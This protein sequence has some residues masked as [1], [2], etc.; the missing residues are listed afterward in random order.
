M[1]LQEPLREAER[2]NFAYFLSI[3]DTDPSKFKVASVKGSQLIPA[4]FE[5]SGACAGCGET[6]NV[7]LISQM[8][9]DRAM[10]A[11]A[12]GC[13]SIYGGT[14]PSVPYT[15]NKAGRGP[16]WANSLFEDNAEFGLGILKVNSLPAVTETVNPRSYKRM[17]ANSPF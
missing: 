10:I 1:A 17:S 6:A 14:A 4:M 12:T 11:N 8:F 9:G 3:P 7:K 15:T 16:A 13:S 5:F 2:E